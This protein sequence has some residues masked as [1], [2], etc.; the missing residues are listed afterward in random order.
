MFFISDSLAKTFQMTLEDFMYR[1]SNR[2]VLVSLHPKDY[3]GLTFR[4]FD[5]I[6]VV[7]WKCLPLQKEWNCGSYKVKFL[8][9]PEMKRGTIYIFQDH[10]VTTVNF[11]QKPNNG[12]ETNTMP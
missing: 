3:E 11:I 12:E 10:Q 9:S 1:N 7:G 4:I 2:E 8:T 5:V 6:D